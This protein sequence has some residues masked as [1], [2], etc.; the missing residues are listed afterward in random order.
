MGYGFGFGGFFMILFWGVLIWAIV[1]LLRGNGFSSGCCGRHGH[2]HNH[3]GKNDAVEI[4]KQR[5]AKGEISKEEFENMKK[6][7]Q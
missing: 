3:G 5:Y 6:D 4:L 2:G 7:L 1:A